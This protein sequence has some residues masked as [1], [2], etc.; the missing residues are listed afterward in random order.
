MKAWG[1]TCFR[2]GEKMLQVVVLEAQYC[3]LLKEHCSS[4]TTDSYS[5]VCLQTHMV[6][7]SLHICS[8]KV[9]SINLFFNFFCISKYT[10]CF[11]QLAN[12]LLLDLCQSPPSHERRE[13]LQTSTQDPWI[14]GW[15]KAFRYAQIPSRYNHAMPP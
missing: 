2:M 8:V 14:S 10:V 11:P 7:W 13:S 12:K 9:Q 6:S 3:C 5:R 4:L 15:V 1:F